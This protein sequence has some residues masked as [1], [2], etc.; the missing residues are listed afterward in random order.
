MCRGNSVP[1]TS[2]LIKYLSKYSTVDN[3][4]RESGTRGATSEILETS[5]DDDKTTETISF[6]FLNLPT[7]IRLYIYEHLLVAYVDSASSLQHGLQAAICLDVWKPRWRVH[8]GTGIL[9]TCRQVYQEARHVLYSQNVFIAR[10]PNELLNLRIICGQEN[11]SMIR[12]LR[13]GISRFADKNKIIEALNTLAKDATSLRDLS[14]FWADPGMV[15][16]G[17]PR[18]RRRTVDG[19]RGPGI[20]VDIARA[21]GSL[22]SVEKLSLSGC[23]AKNWPDYFRMKIGCSIASPVDPSLRRP[24]RIVE[25]DEN[26]QTDEEHSRR[27]RLARS[28]KLQMYQEGTENLWP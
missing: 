9:R 11:F 28:Q 16:P 15:F 7:E 27:C 23:Y 17:C 5:S 19:D 6:A 13:I 25:P 10:R 14:V 2:F 18:R 20:D 1:R 22:T 4:P 21:L 8:M 12:R 3:H 24:W 26:K